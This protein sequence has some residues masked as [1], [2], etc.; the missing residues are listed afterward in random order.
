MAFEVVDA[1]HRLAQRSSQRAGHAR[2]HQQ[3][4]GQARSTGVGHHI[5]IG[6]RVACT[7]HHLAGE[8]QHAPDVVAAGQLGHHAAI[9]LVHLDLAVQRVREQARPARV[10]GLDQGHTGFVAGRFNP[11]NSHNR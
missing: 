8:W 4:A 5:H 10:A 11:Q 7:G 2:A 3:G 1:D 9:G 6:Q